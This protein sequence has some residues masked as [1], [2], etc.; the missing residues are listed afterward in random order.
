MPLISKALASQAKEK[1]DAQKKPAETAK[2]RPLGEKKQ[3]DL[4]NVAS[5]LSYTWQ[6]LD[7]PDDAIKGS[8][9]PSGSSLE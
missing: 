8:H 9:V 4:V 7:P 1:S 2:K 3:K 5:M 6:D